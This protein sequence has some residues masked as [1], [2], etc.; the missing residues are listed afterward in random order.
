MKHLMDNLKSSG[1]VLTVMAVLMVTSLQASADDWLSENWQFNGFGTI[2]YTQTDK[3][4]DR[5]P[6]RNIYQSGAKLR[7]NG[8]LMDSRLG[9]QLKGQLNDHWDVVGQVVARQQ[10]ANN[11]EDY[12]DI[13]F[14][15]YR[16]N[17]EWVFTIGRQAFD[18]F[19]LSDHRNTGYSYD[20][21][22]PPT[23]F[24]GFMPYDS[25]DGIK[26]AK[27]W[28]DFDNDW[29][30]NVSVGNI[31]SKFDVDVLAQSE[32]VDSTKAKP[33]YSTE[34]SWQTGKWQVRASFS[35]LKFEQDLA[36]E[37][38]FNELTGVIRPYWP[39]F[40]RIAEDFSRRANLRYGALGASWQHDGWKVQSE[41]NII[42]SNFIGFNGQRAYFHV[43]KRWQAWQPFVSFGIARDDKQ[44]KYERP[45]ANAQTEIDLDFDL[46]PIYDEVADVVRGMRHN[47]K[48]ISVG[49][50]WDFSAQKALKLQ[51]DKFYFEAG[52]GSIH[53][54]VDLLYAKDESRS[55]CSVAFDWV[56]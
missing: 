35:V 54:S 56:F 23:E 10:L 49:V 31:K 12:I 47:Q 18:L 46:D 13:A 4:D 39:G 19:F 5:I 55:W 42:D 16:A 17:N 51:C 9:L 53:G 24:Y 29:H 40:D 21:I 41:W 28:G 36:G 25:F 50:R 48:S 22:R 43:S 7:D 15:R 52:S 20:W 45:L 32:D 38:E 34:L 8:F 14:A 2:S 30:W 6:R 26:I 37:R 1:R 27:E 11:P 3:Y 33:I 44:F